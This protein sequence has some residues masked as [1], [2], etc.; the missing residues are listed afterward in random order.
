MFLVDAEAPDIGPERRSAPPTG[1]RWRNQPFGDPGGQFGPPPGV[2]PST[3]KPRRSGR[4]RASPPRPRPGRCPLRPWPAAPC[5]PGFVPPGGAAPSLEPSMA[6]SQTG[7]S[8][9]PGRAG[10][11][12]ALRVWARA[13]RP[14][15]NRR[16]EAMRQVGQ[17][18]LPAMSRPGLL[19][20]LAAT[21]MAATFA[22]VV[23]GV[24]AAELREAF[25]LERWQIGALVTATNLVAAAIS[26]AVGRV[27]DRGGCE[28]F[29]RGHPVGQCSRPGRV[30]PG[31][32]LPVAGRGGRARRSGQ[33]GLQPLHQQGDRPPRPPGESGGGDRHQTV[34]SAG[35]GRSWVASPS[36]LW[37][38]GWG[39]DGRWAFSWRCSWRPGWPP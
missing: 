14:K 37:R 38:P 20:V 36:H 4:P 8:R 16:S 18:S 19:V 23:Y 9:E 31:T 12:S 6:G 28:T 25:G 22:L 11:R 5:P 30:G 26:P 2:R 15:T 39:G 3:A 1:S 32:H 13:R 29:H 21:M 35:G 33:C 10:R 27:A 17:A 24:L 7:G 34:R